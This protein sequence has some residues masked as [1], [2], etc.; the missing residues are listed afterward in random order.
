MNAKLA[1]QIRKSAKLLSVEEDG[2]PFP[3][4]GQIE[5]TNKRKKRYDIIKN[6]EGKDEV[7]KTDLSLGMIRN[8]GRTLRGVYRFLKKEFAR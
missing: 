2:T 3:E 5:D 4:F 1:K 6:A 7:K 8:D